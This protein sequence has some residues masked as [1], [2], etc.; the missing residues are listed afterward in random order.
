MKTIK[1]LILILLLIHCAKLSA[2]KFWLTT[3]Q[4]WGGPKTGIVLVNDS[5]FFV[6]TTNSVLRSSNEFKQLDLSLAASE[7]HT[8]FASESGKIYAGGSGKVFFSD[9]SGMS[10]D[11]TGINTTYP[12]KQFTESPGGNMFAITGVYDQGDGV[13]FSG[14]GGLSWTTR[15]NGLGWYP[16]CDQIAVDKN[17][18]LYLATSDEAL[19]G[20]GGLYISENNGL[21]WQKIS[22]GIDSIN[23]AVRI[24]STTNLSVLSNDSVY[25]SFTGSGGN[26]GVEL[27]IFKSIHDIY[28]DSLWKVLNIKHFVITG[29]DK[30]INNIFIARNGDRY[31]SIT[32]SVR[33]GGTCYSKDGKIWDVLDYGLGVDINNRRSEQFFAETKQGRIFMI[34]YMDERVYKTDTSIVT[35]VPKPVELK[36]YIRMYPNPVQKGGNFTL[37]PDKNYDSAE[38]SI[39]TM[40]GMVLFRTQTSTEPMIIPAPEKEGMY[41]VSVR[42][43]NSVKALKIVVN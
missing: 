11:S 15:N 33:L 4:F 28:N 17:G 6:S 9:D 29:M 37:K 19:T 39:C 13:F 42:I 38:I 16:G 3:D 27:N 36:H 41:I 25:L 26:F 22:I 32:E 12:I 1:H 7:I 5:V 2:Q 18:R 30:A 34:Q 31:S 21:Q 35:S 40:T 10:W 43:G 20:Q 8:L 24:G 14:D 23:A